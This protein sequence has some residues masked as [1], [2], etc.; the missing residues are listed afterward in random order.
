MLYLK[1]LGTKYTFLRTIW[2]TTNPHGYVDWMLG[3][4][5]WRTDP[6]LAR[7]RDIILRLAGKHHMD[8]LDPY[9]IAD[10][11]RDLTYDGGHYNGIVGWT[12]ASYVLAHVCQ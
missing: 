3:G 8:V 5:E 7:Y 12:L 10:P 2:L 6:V 1:S 9:S 4:A 11:L